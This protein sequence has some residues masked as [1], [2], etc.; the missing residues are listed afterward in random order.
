AEVADWPKNATECRD[1]RTLHEAALT[2]AAL[3]P[4]VGIEQIDARERAAWQPGQQV[5]GVAEMQADVVEA[6]R[7]DQGQRF[8]HAVDEGLAADEAHARMRARLGA[9]VLAP[10]EADLEADA[11]DRARKQ[12]AQRI[13]R[14]RAV[15]E[16]EPRQQ[17]LHQRRLMRPQ[18]MA[19]APAE[20]GAAASCVAAFARRQS[21]IYV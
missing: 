3:R 11:V 8:R 21:L 9:E 12:R 13:G 1:A 16:R 5:G 14:R 10:A 15:I 4:G 17:R 20:E 18:R 2:V 6:A 7:L 19:L